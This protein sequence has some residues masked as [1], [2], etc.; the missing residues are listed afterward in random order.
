MRRSSTLII[1]L[2]LVATACGPQDVTAETSTTSTAV[3]TTAGETTT[4]SPPS[5]SS[6]TT[7]RP[8]P[9]TTWTEQRS[10][11]PENTR[12]GELLVG[13]PGYVV[14]GWHDKIPG[15]QGARSGL[16]FSNDGSSW[17]EVTPAGQE[18]EWV[19]F[20]AGVWTGTEYVVVTEGIINAENTGSDIEGDGPLLLRSVNGRDWSIEI[21]DTAVV[22]AAPSLGRFFMTPELIQYPGNAGFTDIILGREGLLM[23]GWLNTSEGTEAVVWSS[24]DGDGWTVRRLPGARPNVRAD[25]IERGPLGYVVLGSQQVIG[26]GGGITSVL[27]RSNDEQGW[28]L[29]N[30]P[31]T[32]YPGVELLIPDLWYV[33][34]AAVGPLGYLL[35]GYLWSDTGA[36]EWQLW[37]SDDAKSWAET[38]P[39]PG[40]GAY[41]QDMKGDDDGFLAVGCQTIDEQRLASLWR[42]PDGRSWTTEPVTFPDACIDRLE[43]VGNQWVATGSDVHPD[44]VSNA[45]EFSQATEYIIWTAPDT[46]EVRSVVGVA[47]DDVLNVRSGPGVEYDIIAGLSPTATGVMLTG[48]ETLVGSSVWVEVVTDEG[49]GWV[50]ESYLAEQD[51]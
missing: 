42:S 14:L 39:F 18:L 7:T 17:E 10:A 50:N 20:N 22:A 15:V 37:Y 49:T 43:R 44:S 24:R 33:N 1:G 34:D 40:E 9:V 11:V 36:I 2:A 48:R 47:A 12:L 30:Q 38:G 19:E 8:S 45:S 3:T 32:E 25:R 16:W 29:I 41:I 51:Q 23:T 5:G 26:G 31:S 27:W 35:S 6:T 4:T 46:V 13:S 28:D 21:V